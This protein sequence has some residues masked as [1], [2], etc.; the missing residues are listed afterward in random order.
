M[1][2]EMIKK[3]SKAGLVVVVGCTSMPFSNMIK[4]TA[5]E[6]VETDE[7]QYQLTIKLTGAVD[8]SNYINEATPFIL[9]NTAGNVLNY[10]V[11]NYEKATKTFQITASGVLM[12]GKI[13]LT[14]KEKDNANYITDRQFE[15]NKESIS[16][17]LKLVSSE[18]DLQADVKDGSIRVKLVK[19]VESSIK[20]ITCSYKDK[21]LPFTYDESSQTYSFQPGLEGE[22]AI[23]AALKN[24]SVITKKVVVKADDIKAAAADFSIKHDGK[25]LEWV[26]NAVIS[27][28]SICQISLKP[29]VLRDENVTLELLDENN[30]KIQNGLKNVMHTDGSYRITFQ[31]DSSLADGVYKIKVQG[32]NLNDKEQSFVSKQVILDKTSPVLKESGSVEDGMLI[33]T[34]TEENISLNDNKI[35]IEKDGKELDSESLTEAGIEITQFAKKATVY[36]AEIK[37]K[38]PLAGGSYTVHVL[39]VD[40]TG[41]QDSTTKEFAVETEAPDIQFAV[42]ETSFAKND[43]N[44]HTETVDITED[45]FDADSTDIKIY[46]DEGKNAL[47]K[48]ELLLNGISIGSFKDKKEIK[49]NVKTADIIFSETASEGIYTISVTSTDLHQNTA[50]A[51]KNLVIDRTAAKLAID[52]N[53]EG[54]T[55]VNEGITNKMSSITFSVDEKNFIADEA[56][57]FVNGKR[58][59]P[60]WQ[61]E[62]GTNTHRAVLENP[63]EGTYSLALD[64]TDR[65]GNKAEQKVKEFIYDKTPV[66]V[67]IKESGEEWSDEGK[68]HTK[69]ASFTYAL[70]DKDAGI[71]YIVYRI[72]DI[73][74]YEKEYKVTFSNDTMQINGSDVLDKF[75]E[76]GLSIFGHMKNGEWFISIQFTESTD[77]IVSYEC[78][79]KANNKC[80]GELHLKQDLKQPEFKDFEALFEHYNMDDATW[81]NRAYTVEVDTKD[82]FSEVERVEYHWDNEIQWKQ[83]VAVQ[84]TADKYTIVNDVADGKMY[85]GSLYMR[86]TDYAGNISET[87][88]IHIN[89]DKVA[90]GIEIQHTG[91][92]QHDTYYKEAVKD[93]VKISEHSFDTAVINFYKNGNLLSEETVGQEGIKVDEQWKKT[94]DEKDPQLFHYTKTIQFPT[95]KD[96]VYKYEVIA[97]DKAQN[98]TS[99]TS[100]TYI[101]DYIDPIADISFSQKQND[102]FSD[103]NYFLQDAVTAHFDVNEHNFD[104]DLMKVNVIKDGKKYDAYTIGNWSSSGDQHRLD[105]TFFKEGHYTV[106]LNGKD[107]SGRNLKTQTKTFVIDQTL[108]EIEKIT[109][110]EKNS[111]LA[112]SLANA[113][114]FGRFFQKEVEV[115]IYAKDAISGI[116]QIYFYYEG[117]DHNNKTDT[118]AGNKQSFTSDH[119]EKVKGAVKTVNGN[120]MIVTFPIAPNFKGRVYAAVQD[121]AGNIEMLKDK[122]VY[123]SSPYGIVIEDDAQLHTKIKTDIVINTNP[124]NSLKDGT[125]LFRQDVPVQLEIK[126]P[127]SGIKQVTYQLGDMDPVTVKKFGAGESG[128]CEDTVIKDTVKSQPGGLNDKN[129]VVI[130]VEVIDNA[131]QKRTFSKK[132]AI[133]QTA[134]QLSYDY[135]NN[136]VANGHY[137]NKNRRLTLHIRELNFEPEKVHINVIENGVVSA[138]TPKA[139]SWKS[140]GIDHTAVI[141]FD[142]DADYKVKMSYTDRAGNSGNS[143]KFDDFTIDTRSPKAT[144]S[145]DNN[146]SRNGKYFNNA[147][148]ATIKVEE[149]NFNSSKFK[150]V[151]TA[152]NDGK[153]MS[154]PSITGWTK[155][156]D[157]HTA[158]VHFNSDADYSM[159]LS[160]SD[161]A[162]NTMN[163]LPKDSFTVDKKIPE[164]SIGNVKNLSSNRKPVAPNIT[165]SDIN[166]DIKNSGIQVEG[167]D[168][169][170]VKVKAAEKQAK[171]SMSYEME[172]LKLDDNYVVT[173]NV[174]DM[175][176]NKTN[177]STSFS[178]N[179]NGSVFILKQKL[180]NKK[181]VNSPFNPSI[182]IKNVDEVS[183]MSLTLNG[184]SVPYSLVNGVLT[185]D[186]EI[187]QNGKYIINLQ[188]RDAAGNVNR[189]SPIE[190]IYDDEKPVPVF[191]INKEQMKDIYFGPLTLTMKCE[192]EADHITAVYLNNVKL[193]KSQYTIHEDG[194][195]TVKVSDYGD[196]DVRFEMMD[197]AGNKAVSDVYHFTLSNNMLLRYFDNKPLFYGSIAT[198][199]GLG[200]AG[201]MVLRLRKKK[202]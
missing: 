170:K 18:A 150:A 11:T 55:S 5:T 14:V 120:E 27:D 13:L 68:W 26:D 123:V 97:Q 95:D 22:Y 23:K 128:I 17:D 134:P 15:I 99:K 75:T 106:T 81:T 47:T 187:N 61:L 180:T 24:G 1:S 173:A 70:K 78:V 165:Y 164:V 141:I 69:A 19:D 121:K 149:H 171:H 72:K 110:K 89:L 119:L 102:K 130:R 9:K 197:D 71:K 135:D 41:K 91:T 172:P 196:Y 77:S 39:A 186:K 48:Q 82:D 125:M 50:E 104:K 35:W 76:N 79:D 117:E 103:D 192:K 80:E 191:L 12:D 16:Q 160:Y 143:L 33:Y 131:G 7:Q 46:K 42:P 29:Y 122:P 199:L 101:L 167:T 34:V 162:E 136:N 25:E 20:E 6:I 185:I 67:D 159:Q 108:P 52:T 98:L 202:V 179:Q 147:R 87:K 64:Y 66:Q 158:Q 10:E 124:V 133:D 59:T 148:T 92:A 183:I 4:A 200:A 152:Q 190:F 201:V 65:A 189:M 139:S 113:A 175:A 40:K 38:K 28:D 36:A 51:K 111:N 74:G 116:D 30:D 174:L 62:T 142:N 132:I 157:I 144:L 32:K 155:N 114:T 112:A 2:K 184:V 118:I 85:S 168:N 178:V 161:E 115:R 43:G 127:F 63:E 109:F 83:A 194:S 56:V 129:N 182:T 94:Q 54:N 163:T 153:Q 84:G 53:T 90:P 100:Q 151:F 126:A 45:N 107:L 58:I 31:L 145:Y 96:G 73:N 8:L 176:G 169:G 138:K 181:Y 49:T 86:I 154:A 166:L 88:E 60:Q 57:V 146:G 188:V 137:Y 93:I 195:V 44:A 105:L 177:K 193:N 198:T 140:E 156:G 21:A 3:V 37:F